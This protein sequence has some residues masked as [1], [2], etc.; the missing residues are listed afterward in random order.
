MALS[1]STL[2]QVTQGGSVSGTLH[3]VTSDGAGPYKAMVDTTG[4]GTSW[5][6]MEVVTQ[7]PGINDSSN[8][9]LISLAQKPE[10]ILLTPEVCNANSKVLNRY[11]G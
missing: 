5:T 7:V 10:L 3:I 2:P 11:Q 4:T 1:G 6:P 8:P 9:C